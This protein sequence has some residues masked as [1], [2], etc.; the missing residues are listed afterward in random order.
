MIF[1]LDKFWEAA[2]M[3]DKLDMYGDMSGF[4]RTT[5]LLDYFWSS[6]CVFLALT[7]LLLCSAVAFIKDE[8]WVWLKW[9]IWVVCG[10]MIIITCAVW[11]LII[12]AALGFIGGALFKRR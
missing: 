5:A 1:G 7:L 3:P 6:D 9:V 12:A 11:F 2:T 4:A 8:N 10:I